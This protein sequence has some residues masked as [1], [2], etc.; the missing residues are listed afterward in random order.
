MIFLINKGLEK[1][2]S[3]KIM[4]SVRKGK[5]LT[6]EMEEAMIAN[7]KLPDW[8]IDSCKKIKY[9]FPKAHAVAYVMMA[10]R[11][12]WF[13][14]YRPIAYYCAFLG[15]RAKAFDYEKMCN[16]SDR[17]KRE[18]DIL[19][20]QAADKTISN[21]DEDLLA[22]M[23]IVQEMYAR[24]F[25][26]EKVN[27]Y[28]SEAKLFHEKNGKIQPSFTSIPGLGENVAVA[29]ETEAKKKPFATI[30]EFVERTGANKTVVQ[31]LKDNGILDGIP[32]SNQMSLF[33]DFNM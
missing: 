16:G 18:M 5:G 2:L 3:F 21:K 9:M 23:K 1:G 14:V 32:E 26:F 20:Q 13:K 11:I 22:A 10:W 28:E 25:E 8:Y 24:G 15:I 12:A 31:I 27:L 29:I 19:K 6:P 7:G 17:L 30:D 33:D 4:E